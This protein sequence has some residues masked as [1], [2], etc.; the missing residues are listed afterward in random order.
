MTVAFKS[1]F[2]GETIFWRPSGQPIKGPISNNAILSKPK[3]YLI[4]WGTLWTSDT[5]SG[6]ASDAKAILESQYLSSLTQYGSSG[7]AEYGGYAVDTR[8]SQG[9]PGRDAEINYVLDSLKPSWTKPTAE[10]PNKTGDNTGAVGY[11]T[12]PIYAVIGDS[13]GGG[14]MNGGG[15]YTSG[16]KTYLTNAIYIN[17]GRDRNGFNE[18]FSH[19]LVERISDGNGNG[20]GMN[21]S[22]DI[23]GESS[24]AQLSDNEPDGE[25]YT[26][27]LN[28]TL[29][30]QAYWSVVDQ[31]FI[32][33][34]GNGQ[35]VFL[36]P[37]WNN[38]SFTG[39]FD[40]LAVQTNRSAAAPT[41]AV[42]NN[43]RTQLTLW[44]ETFN[45]S[46]SSIQG[47]SVFTLS[48]VNQNGQVWHIGGPG[49]S[50]SAITGTNTNA[51]QLVTD[52]T[53]AFMMANNGDG[54]H[55]WRYNNSGIAWTDI[56]GASTFGAGNSP[57]QLAASGGRLYTLINSVHSGGWNQVWQYGGSGS[58][59]AAITG[60]NTSIFK[61]AASRCGL[62]MLASNGGVSQ[63]WQYSGSDSIWTAVTG[64]DTVVFTLVECGGALY[65]L[66][67]NGDGKHIWRY[68]GLGVD[69]T[70][71]TGTN[72]VA[73][74]LVDCGGALYMLANNGDGDHVWQYHGPAGGWT[75]VTG[76]G[77]HVSQIVACGDT[78][79]MLANNGDGNHVWRYSGSGVG[80]TAITG[81][82]TTVNQISTLGNSLF[83]SAARTG[84]APGTWRYSGS[85]TT[86][87]LQT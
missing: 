61:L 80:W 62:F 20:I 78:L 33:P 51:L 1:A 79:Y 34:D 50:W 15:F 54:N 39:T 40:L 11:L 74:E 23:S 66:A 83:M 36:A 35:T 87:T 56:T 17:N 37:I 53:S 2:G 8:A 86:W 45:F 85:G 64:T 16:S 38:K 59:W 6:H 72:T 67:N 25:R 49:T 42:I 58:S 81:A 57:W 18:L 77:T 84:E 75:A 71:I 41:S 70:T 5:A 69:W 73:S 21:A 30:V 13:G 63:V 32:V 27:R 82:N 3:V 14:A 60:D 47:V 19:E 9:L 7:T 31:T 12:S 48:T 68:G 65:M 22:V 43:N 4:F 24:D 76:A 26:Y 55:I 52:G 28:G 10:A 44:N 46:S 29:E